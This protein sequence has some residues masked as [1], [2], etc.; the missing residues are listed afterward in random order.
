MLE[1]GWS[2]AVGNLHKYKA[3]L[4]LLCFIEKYH[5]PN[6]SYQIGNANSKWFKTSLNER[7]TIYY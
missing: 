3:G 7:P 6:K 5:T 2:Y 1:S 4:I